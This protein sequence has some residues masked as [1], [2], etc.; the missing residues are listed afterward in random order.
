VDIQDYIEAKLTHSLHTSERLSYRG[1]RRRWNWLFNDRMYP[2][3]TAKP[4]EFGSAFHKGFETL[5]DPVMWNRGDRETQ[6]IQAELAFKNM[7]NEQKHEY[8]VKNDGQIDPEVEQDYAERIELGVG[9]LRYHWNNVSPRL[10]ATL[11][12][13]RVEIEFEVPINGPDGEELWCKCHNC[14][15]MWKNSDA[16]TKHH[17]I[18]QEQNNVRPASFELSTKHFRDIIVSAEEVENLYHNDFWRGLP[19]TYGGRIDCLMEDE[20]GRLWI[21]DWKTAARLS[22]QEVQDSPD[23]FIQL[24]DQI[25]SYCWA[26][27]VL[28][29]PIAGFIH[30]EVKKAFPIEPEPNKTKRKG[31]WYSV[32]KMQDTSYDL[33]LQTITENDP[34]GLASGAYDEFL[35]YLKENGPR[36]YSRK[37]VARNETE[38]RN[39]GYN[40]FL[41]AQEMIRPDLPIYP[42]PGRF[43]CSFCAFRQPC[44]ATNQ[45]ED[46]EYLFA[47]SFEH[48][49]RRYWEKV[50]L[51]TES[52]GGR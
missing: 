31:C 51:S 33:Y 44:I 26:L 2:T 25:T 5:Y 27:W 18:F 50:P 34:S 21:V 48:R 11:K 1:C 22:G 20:Y 23:E 39:A 17:N 32:N 52:K 14:W 10:D 3:T 15:N 30:H 7:C 36:Y 8:L 43:A 24:D 42:S 47:S 13:I 16:G 40:I 46:V 45:G 49:E 28:G 12:P 35:E 38:L 19:V 29:I 4:L 6:L 9:M 37:Q 41:E